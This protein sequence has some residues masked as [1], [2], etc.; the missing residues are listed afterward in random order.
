MPSVTLLRTVRIS[1]AVLA[2]AGCATTGTRASDAAHAAR[3][4]RPPDVHGDPLELL[5]HGAVAW[6]RA[7]AATLR[8]SPH[9]ESGM[10]LARELG[11]DLAMVERELGFDPFRTADR[12][13]FAIYPPPG[14][15]AE[16]GWPLVY[17]RGVIQREAILAAAR[18]RAEGHAPTDGTE[19]G[20]AY[21]VVGNR[22]YVFP[23]SDVVMVMERALVRRVT[24]RLA[25]DSQRTV[26]TDDRF[27]D[28]WREAGGS[29]GPFALAMDLS[30]MRARMH[31]QSP[32]PEAEALE[33][34]VVH[35]DAPG[36][37]TVRAA[38]EASD[39]N[40]AHMIV[41]TIDDARREAGGQLAV[42]LLGLSRVLREGI[43]ASE[44]GRVVRV[45]VDASSD[46]VRRLL[47]AT[48][49]LRELTG[50]S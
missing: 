16:G 43:R 31:V 32:S 49:L 17:A 14:E 6:G 27:R 21:T 11:A 44:D 19:H 30:A 33:A 13:A 7:D 15:R 35:G 26:L 4:R 46:E 12:V 28:L 8:A 24:A 45:E 10:A 40:A 39:P 22:A 18:A 48:A 37:V 38:G 29:G 36:A 41:R 3:A 5:P 25:G 42:R 20:V 1:L 2:L 47:R 34:F 50:R 9:Y 23:A